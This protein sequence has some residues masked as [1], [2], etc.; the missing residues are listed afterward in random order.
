MRSH[1]F[2]VHQRYRQKCILHPETPEMNLL[3]ASSILI[4]MVNNVIHAK[5][6]STSIKMVITVRTKSST[7]FLLT[8]VQM[9]KF[10]NQNGAI[11]FGPNGVGFSTRQRLRIRVWILNLPT[12]SFFPM[13]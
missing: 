8:V 2:L 13:E 12:A 6:G 11:K 9:Q 1:G 7:W 5:F 3:S 10:Q 4:M